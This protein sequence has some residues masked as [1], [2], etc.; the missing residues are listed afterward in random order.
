[1]SSSGVRPTASR[2]APSAAAPTDASTDATPKTSAA[3]PSSVSRYS[4]TPA[5]S[6]RFSSPVKNSADSSRAAPCVALQ[7]TGPRPPAVGD[8]PTRARR[9]ASGST[10]VTLSTGAGHRT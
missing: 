1:M 10:F 4:T 8:G 2:N 9:T 7:A 6:T 3:A 5:S